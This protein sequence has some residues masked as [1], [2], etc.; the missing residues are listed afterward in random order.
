M[1]SSAIVSIDD[2]QKL[3]S[4]PN[5]IIL[6]CT[7]DKVNQK[8]EQNTKS[9]P[10]A[11]FFDIEHTFSDLST[12]LPHSVINAES[13]TF[14]AQRLGI[15][16]D[17]IIVL[18][19]RWGVYSSPRAW[20]M[21]RYM[22]HKQVYVLNGGLPAWEKAN[23]PLGDQYTNHEAK[24][25]FVASIQTEWFADKSLVLSE[26][27]NELSKTIDARGTGRFEGTVPEP[28][29]GVRAGH[30]PNSD[31]IPFE[32]VLSGIHLKPTAELAAIFNPHTSHN[33]HLI[34]TCGSGITAC[35]LALAA[36]ETGLHHIKVY[37]GSWAEWG[38]DNTLPIA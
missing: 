9:I 5:L 22:G 17:S 31:N 25:N 2:L 18:Y 34:F 12:G 6:D 32:T 24:G 7:I 27:N 33:E 38:A 16:H 11:Q 26:I 21:F 30:I 14:Y 35:I 3:S 1:Q 20:W 28:R 15:N 13:F 29:P 23:L 4:N 10:K 8:I 37:D 36:Y 19:D